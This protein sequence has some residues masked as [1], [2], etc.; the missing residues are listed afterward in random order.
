MHKSIQLTFNKIICKELKDFWLRVRGSRLDSLQ[1]IT[2]VNSPNLS[3]FISSKRRMNSSLRVKHRWLEVSKSWCGSGK[4]PQLLWQ[5]ESRWVLRPPQRLPVLPVWW[6][7]AVNKV[8]KLLETCQ[9]AAEQGSWKP[10][11]RSV[12]T[13]GY[14]FFQGEWAG[15]GL[16]DTLPAEAPGKMVAFPVPVGESEREKPHWASGKEGSK[17]E[18]VVGDVLWSP[19]TERSRWLVSVFPSPWELD[20]LAAWLL[21]C[22]EGD[23]I[24]TEGADPGAPGIICDELSTVDSAVVLW[25][26]SLTWKNSSSLQQFV[27]V[28]L[29]KWIRR[30]LTFYFCKRLSGPR[31]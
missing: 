15:G 20:H 13:A 14:L 3:D 25:A 28:I 16:R 30:L 17:R 31:K 8:C 29:G 11:L 27:P 19:P 26:L 6:S 5:L 2:K 1:C 4:K 21:Y 12:P 10:W 24:N 18:A 22:G 23:L 9:D 7:G